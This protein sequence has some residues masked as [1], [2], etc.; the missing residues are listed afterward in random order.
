[1]DYVTYD[2]EGKLTG[3]YCQNL[4]Q[5]HADNYIEV[6]AQ[7]RLEWL[8]YRANSKR[9][10]IEALPDP[11]QRQPTMEEVNAPILKQLIDIDARSIRALRE[12]NADRINALEFEASELRS[13][14]IK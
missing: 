3:G 5:S 9:D 1:M 8:K 10:G 14:L 13:R 12:G 11:G 4:H 6:T 2:D 7:E